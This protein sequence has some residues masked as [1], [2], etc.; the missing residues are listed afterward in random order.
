MAIKHINPKR[1]EESG[2]FV[3]G[4][5]AEKIDKIF[6]D[7]NEQQKNLKKFTSLFNKKGDK[8][9]SSLAHA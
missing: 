2:V 6:S 3:S 1:K 5:D 8:N 9:V 4:A 7:K